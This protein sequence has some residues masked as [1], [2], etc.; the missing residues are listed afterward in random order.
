MMIDK[1]DEL[2]YKLNEEMDHSNSNIVNNFTV[3]FQKLII[4]QDLQI[5]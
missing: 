4:I 1:R 2:I 5:I 3:L